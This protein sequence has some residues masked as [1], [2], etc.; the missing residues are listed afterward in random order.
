MDSRATSSPLAELSR[1][2]EKINDMTDRFFSVSGLFYPPISYGEKIVELASSL[3]KKTES[4][5]VDSPL[6]NL[7]LEN[8]RELLENVVLRVKNWIEGVQSYESFLQEHGIGRNEFLE[9]KE[10]A[11]SHDYQEVATGFVE[12]REALFYEPVSSERYIEELRKLFHR[13][14]Q[15]SFSHSTASKY[16]ESFKNY[17]ETVHI[18]TPGGGSFHI[19]GRIQL[20]PSNFRVAMMCEGA[21]VR[22]ML[23]IVHASMVLGEEGLTG[24][25]GHYYHTINSR[26]PGFMKHSR[27]VGFAIREC[28]GQLGAIYLLDIVSSLP[29]VREEYGRDLDLLLE[30]NRLDRE[31]WVLKSYVS[32]CGEYLV[33]VDGWSIDEVAGYITSLTKWKYYSTPET[34]KRIEH[35][36]RDILPQKKRESAEAWARVYAHYL[37]EKIAGHLSRLP[38][39]ERIEKMG[40]LMKGYWA[41]NTFKKYVEHVLG[42][43]L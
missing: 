36:H 15:V 33:E 41:P 5:K 25:Q 19:S 42:A 18:G 27:G 21:Q 38:E 11:E 29:E 20:D 2:M 14:L 8:L 9:I 10:W 23:D 26:L 31:G 1:E 22:E 17:L 28:I 24:H 12:S 13:L 3:K 39:K 16:F 35:Y 37:A 43:S 32:L 4:M 34:K 7:Y 30:Y 40:E 6:E